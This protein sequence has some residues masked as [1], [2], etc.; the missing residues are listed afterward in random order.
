MFQSGSVGQ[1]GCVGPVEVQSGS[2]IPACVKGGQGAVFEKK[3]YFHVLLFE[4]GSELE[5]MKLCK[6]L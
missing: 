4:L 2:K 1:S 3:Y 6:R 5:V